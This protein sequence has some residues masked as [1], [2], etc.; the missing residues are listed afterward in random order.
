MGG[1]VT[2]VSKG[3]DV[4][5]VTNSWGAKSTSSIS[6]VTSSGKVSITVVGWLTSLR[7][8]DTS[9]IDT[10][11]NGTCV[12]IVTDHWSVGTNVVVSCFRARISGTS[13]SIIT[14][15]RGVRALSSK[16]ITSIIGTEQSITARFWDEYASSSSWVAA[17][18]GTCIIIVTDDSL[19]EVWSSSST[20]SEVGEGDVWAASSIESTSCNSNSRWDEIDSVIG[21]YKSIINIDCIIPT[22]IDN[23]GW[24]ADIVSNGAAWSSS[25]GVGAGVFSESSVDDPGDNELR[26]RC[27]GLILIDNKDFVESEDGSS[28]SINVGAEDMSMIIIHIICRIKR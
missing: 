14:S 27:W 22:I 2:E 24:G 15:D 28:S 7:S 19:A 17:I 13:V 23:L 9:S 18:S 6:R 21:V 20:D 10:L 11:I 5:V 12:V 16:R 4:V 25:V 3:T 26:S 1:S 8:E